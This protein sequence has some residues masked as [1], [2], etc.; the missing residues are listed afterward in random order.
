MEQYIKFWEQAVKETEKF[1][2]DNLT[3][4]DGDRLFKPVGEIDTIDWD[5]ET[6]NFFRML[7]IDYLKSKDD[8]DLEKD[9]R[10]VITVSFMIGGVPKK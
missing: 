1:K 8:F 6:L 7:V 2:V 3:A 4:S 9:I 5:M 10:N